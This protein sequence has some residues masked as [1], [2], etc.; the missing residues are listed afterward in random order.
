MKKNKAT[1]NIKVDPETYDK[2]VK[3]AEQ[4]GRTIA[5]DVRMKYLEEKV[6]R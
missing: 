6:K 5:G 1:K 2:I 3:A 4:N